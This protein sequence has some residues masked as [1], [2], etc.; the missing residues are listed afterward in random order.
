MTPEQLSLEARGLN[1]KA[2]AMDAAVNRFKRELETN[3]HRTT[4]GWVPVVWLCAAMETDRRGIRVL[5]NAAK[6]QV[7]A[8]TEDGG[9][10]KLTV[11]A[12]PAE[13]TRAVRSMY[14]RA[15]AE[16]MRAVQTS[17]VFHNAG[18]LLEP[19]P[20]NEIVTMK[21]EGTT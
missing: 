10:Y 13:T 4:D 19:I 21:E 8:R 17:R 20:D 7:I 15:K 9:G 5:A 6:G 18:K 11:H 14:A 16:T 12:T 3:P 1:V 2:Q